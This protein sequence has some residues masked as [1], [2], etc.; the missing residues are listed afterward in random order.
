MAIAEKLLLLGGLGLVANLLPFPDSSYLSS[1]RYFSFALFM[2]GLTIACD[3]DKD[4]EIR[5]MANLGIVLTVFGL[6]GSAY[7]VFAP[8]YGP[9]PTQEPL[10]YHGF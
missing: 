3:K 5:S 6:I 1:T 4:P 10:R 9:F 7:R 2:M 8:E